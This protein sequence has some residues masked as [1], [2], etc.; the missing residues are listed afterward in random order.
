MQK[1]KFWYQKFFSIKKTVVTKIVLFETL[2]MNVQQKLRELIFEK[3]VL[4][5]LGRSR[6]RYNKKTI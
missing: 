4:W 1:N 5:A 2:K 3:R 6:T